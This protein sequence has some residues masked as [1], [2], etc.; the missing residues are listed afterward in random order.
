MDKHN[1]IRSYNVKLMTTKCLIK[2]IQ[3]SLKD[4][5]NLKI[6]D[7]KEKVQ[8]KWNVGVNKTKVV[9]ARCAARGL[10][11][12]FFLEQYTRI[13]DYIDEIL[14]TNFGSTIKID[15]QLVLYNVS[16]NKSHFQRM[17]ICY[18]ACKE[19]FKLCRP[20][21]GLDGYFLKGLLG[22]QILAAIRRDPNY[23]MMPISFEVV[24]RETKD[25]WTWFIELLIEDLGGRSQCC[26]YTF[27]SDQ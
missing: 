1:F 14:K 20:I 5:Q 3:N 23:Q 13:Y 26:T 6:R 22:G 11:D 19:S 2:R 27:I 12:G 4:N 16:D 18:A 21:I 25:N 15:V 8:R 9:M 17:Y 24:E 10:V 7:I